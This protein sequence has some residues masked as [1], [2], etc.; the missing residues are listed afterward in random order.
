ML[1]KSLYFLP[2][3]ATTVFISWYLDERSSVGLR[4]LLT[5]VFISLFIIPILILW[6]EVQ[7]WEKQLLQ[8]FKLQCPGCGHSLINVE[9][10]IAIASGYFGKCGQQVHR[11]D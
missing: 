6:K 5:F 1:F 3:V 9:G 4:Y 11:G 10:S 8:Q 7:K 2:A